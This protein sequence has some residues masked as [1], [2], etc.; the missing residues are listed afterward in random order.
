ML[1]W[2]LE[3]RRER[4]SEGCDRPQLAVRVNVLRVVMDMK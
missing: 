3:E 4:M 1:T 2:K